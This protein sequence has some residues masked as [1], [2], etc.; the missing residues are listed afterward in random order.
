MRGV[1]GEVYCEKV[2]M[3]HT[4]RM[5]RGDH[6]YVYYTEH[7]GNNTKESKTCNPRGL[8]GN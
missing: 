1:G 7:K 5:K 8:E 2:T 6:C 3:K 4:G